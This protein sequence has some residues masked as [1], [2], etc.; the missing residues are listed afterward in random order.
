MS[1]QNGISRSK[2]F[3]EITCESLKRQKIRQTVVVDNFDQ[4]FK[5]FSRTEWIDQSASVKIN[6]RTLLEGIPI[7]IEEVEDIYAPLAKTILEQTSSKEE[8]D[9]EESIRPHTHQSRPFILGVT[10]GVSVGK[11]SIAKVLQLLLK[12][13][14]ASLNV[15]VVST[16]GFLFPNKKLQELNIMHRKGFPESYNYSSIVAFLSSVKSSTTKQEAPVYS[17]T[18]YDVT[19]TKQIIDNPDVLIIEGL[20]LLQDHP[21]N[22]GD[23]Q[24]LFIR[25]FLDCCIFLDAEEIDVKSWYISRFLKLCKE[26]KKDNDSFFNRYKDFSEEEAREEASMIWD[27]INSINLKENIV[28]LKLRADVILSKKKSHMIWKIAFKSF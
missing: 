1:G 17:H 2:R 26:A 15:D 10:G 6:H 11:S 7:P 22:V 25:E 4:N 13:I 3:I 24:Q 14:D 27:L 21:G 16:D 23:H 8:Q 19:S 5:S 20:N 18:T 28:P 12:T 9:A